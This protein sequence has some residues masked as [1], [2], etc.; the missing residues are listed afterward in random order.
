MLLDKRLALLRHVPQFQFRFRSG[1]I[2]HDNRRQAP[3]C[4]HSW[5]WKLCG[6]ELPES[7]L[8]AMGQEVVKRERLG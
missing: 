1:H 7:L 2:T 3:V 4:L 6:I 8:V 5:T